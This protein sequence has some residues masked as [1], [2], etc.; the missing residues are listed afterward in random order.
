ML[1]GGEFME[2]HC[3]EGLHLHL[4]ML[5]SQ[6]LVRLD[7]WRYTTIYNAQFFLLNAILNVNI[8]K[9][10]LPSTN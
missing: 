1:D 2:L 6:L 7:L 5:D 4:E 8:L 10:D 9:C 3:L